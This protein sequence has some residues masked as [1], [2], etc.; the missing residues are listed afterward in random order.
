MSRE[1][2]RSTDASPR[3]N[4]NARG[5]RWTVAVIDFVL[6]LGLGYLGVKLFFRRGGDFFSHVPDEFWA[7]LLSGYGIWV[8]YSSYHLV[9][10]RPPACWQTGKRRHWI[11]AALGLLMIAVMWLS[12]VGNSQDGFGQAVGVFYLTIVASGIVIF[13]LF[14]AAVMSKHA[15]KELSGTRTGL[16][17][18]LAEELKP[19]SERNED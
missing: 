3:S 4:S 10:E 14:A 19:P 8:L 16:F 6:G 7:V 12:L 18:R 2:Q 1:N 17:K 13:W 5:F 9:T 15:P 11:S